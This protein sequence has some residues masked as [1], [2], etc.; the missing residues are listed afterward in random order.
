MIQLLPFDGDFAKLLPYATM[1]SPN[2]YRIRLLAVNYDGK[3][4]FLDLLTV[5]NGYPV[6]YNTENPYHLYILNLSANPEY[7]NYKIV[8]VRYVLKDWVREV[9][10]TPV[11]NFVGAF[12]SVGGTF[13][14]LSELRTVITKYIG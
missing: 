1:S 7:T 2:N 14:E 12:H 9:I 10:D 11:L 5:K 6:Y 3:Y 13:F 4:L 8:V